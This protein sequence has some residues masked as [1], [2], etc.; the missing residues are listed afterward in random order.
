MPETPYSQLLSVKKLA[1]KPKS[2]ITSVNAID[3]F[4][5]L[6]GEL[7]EGSQF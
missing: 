3:G 6:Q 4:V 7:S 2:R 1:I 5:D